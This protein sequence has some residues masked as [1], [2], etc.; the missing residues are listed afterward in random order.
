MGDSLS[1]FL[2]IASP[3][4]AIAVFGWLMIRRRLTRD[5]E[6]ISKTSKTFIYRAVIHLLVRRLAISLPLDGKVY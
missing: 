4:G 2:A 3:K 1:Y 5:D 6:K